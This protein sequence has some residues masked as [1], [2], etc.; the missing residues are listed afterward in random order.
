MT[1]SNP[2][3]RPSVAQQRRLAKD[4]AAMGVED[5]S[6]VCDNLCEIAD[7]GVAD[8]SLDALDALAYQL[9]VLL[10]ELRSRIG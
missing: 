8:E 6:V 3:L 9:P 2:R 10:A 1:R 5:L 7:Q 4:L